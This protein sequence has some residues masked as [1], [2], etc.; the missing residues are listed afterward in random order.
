MTFGR[1]LS[2]SDLRCTRA[3]FYTDAVGEWT[4]L[5]QGPRTAHW[6]LLELALGELGPPA[7]HCWW[8]QMLNVTN[9]DLGVDEHLFLCELRG[10]ASYYDQLICLQLAFVEAIARRVQ[11]K[12]VERLA[13]K[14]RG[15]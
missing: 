3:R 14:L 7:R 9:R 5:V 15:H 4:F 10:Y 8:R 1:L 12:E 6:L 2:M 13:E 11:L